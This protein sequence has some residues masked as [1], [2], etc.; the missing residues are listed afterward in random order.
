MTSTDFYKRQILRIVDIRDGLRCHQN[1]ILQELCFVVIFDVQPKSKP[2]VLPPQVQTIF[3]SIIL[4]ISC[5]LHAAHHIGAFKR[6]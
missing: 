5:P 2:H 4:R 1:Y 3:T 6:R